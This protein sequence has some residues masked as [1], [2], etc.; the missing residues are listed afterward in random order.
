[1][2]R[3]IIIVEDDPAIS[4]ILSIM[5]KR[6]GFDVEEFILG[7]PLMRE[8]KTLPDLFLLDKQLTD[9]DGLE[10]CRHLKTEPATREIPVIIVSATPDLQSQAFDAG[11]D[12]FIE[13]PFTSRTLLGKIAE[14]L[15]RPERIDNRESSIVNR[16]S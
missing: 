7:E 15:N 8:L 6:N 2:K 5:L 12:A 1:M 3:R 16:Q 14:L 4:D 11:A 9:I 10:I 13:K